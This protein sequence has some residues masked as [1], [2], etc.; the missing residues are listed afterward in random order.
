MIAALAPWGTVW[1]SPRMT[2]RR[3]VDS[4]AR[5]S[6]VPVVA[7]AAMTQALGSLQRDP[8]DLTFSVSWS[9]MPVILGVLQLVFGVLVGPFLLAFAGGWL[10]GQAD[11]EEIRPAVAWS[12]VPFALA[13]LLWIPIL[14]AYGGPMSPAI[15]PQDV[16]QWLGLLFALVIFAAVWWSLVLEVIMLAEVQRFSILRALAS[17]IILMIPLL[18]M[19]LLR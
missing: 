1:F 10:G 9:T 18:L 7:L 4:E 12:L 8:A 15:Q 13:G 19:G 2:I 17:V 16:F 14:L 6:W 11:P 5:P 3:I